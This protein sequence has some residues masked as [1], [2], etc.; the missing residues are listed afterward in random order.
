MLIAW[1]AEDSIVMVMV[2][3]SWHKVGSKLHCTISYSCV[4]SISWLCLQTKLLI[5]H[6]CCIK[7]PFLA[8]TCGGLNHRIIFHGNSRNIMK[9]VDS[10]YNFT[11]WWVYIITLRFFTWWYNV[12][13]VCIH[14]W[15]EMVNLFLCHNIFTCI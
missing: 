14:E 4:M 13:S 1:Y 9:L 12:M 3:K 10:G 11:I 7:L 15:R 5:D 8:V 6:F 2:K